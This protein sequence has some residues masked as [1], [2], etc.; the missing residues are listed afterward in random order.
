MQRI[1]R[2]EL[3]GK[4]FWYTAGYMSDGVPK[5]SEW[6]YGGTSYKEAERQMHERFGD[7]YQPIGPEAINA[8]SDEI[9]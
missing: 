3:R 8:M 9:S 4:E 7:D 2:I 1:F 6:Q 5:L